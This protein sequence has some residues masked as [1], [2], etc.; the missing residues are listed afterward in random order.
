M[1]LACSQQGCTNVASTLAGFVKH[2]RLHQC[3]GVSKI[4]CPLDNCLQ[5]F[6]FSK[7]LA[8]HLKRS[9]GTMNEIQG[10]NEEFQYKCELF[11]CYEMELSSIQ[12]LKHHLQDHCK[13]HESV[14]CVFT[15]CFQVYSCPKK[16]RYHF[17]NKHRHASSSDIKPTP[18]FVPPVSISMPEA[19]DSFNDIDMSNGENEDEI[20]KK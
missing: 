19:N 12:S 15:N 3:C 14:K 2:S 11:S 9:H 10:N 20:S 5:K 17:N 13:K 6:K 1:T 18:Y 4:Q 8:K 7:S 16:L